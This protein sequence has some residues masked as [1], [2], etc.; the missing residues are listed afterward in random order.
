MTQQ[1]IVTARVEPD[2]IAI[3]DRF[4]LEVTV[5]KDVMQMVDFP[6]FEQGDL[7]VVEDRAVDTL[8]SEG[9]QMTLRKSWT[10]TTFEDGRLSL[11]RVPVL[12]IDKNITDTLLSRDSLVLEVGTFKID[13]ATMTIRDLKP[14]EKAPVK[15]GE[16]SGW[17]GLGLL[18]AA[19]VGMLLWWL[20]RKKRVAEEAVSNELPHERATREL[21]EL[22][23]RKLWQNGK[24]KQYYT[25]L[26]DIL[27]NYLEARWGVA[28][29][30]MTSDEILAAVPETVVL[31]EMLRLADLVKFARMT[32]E[33]EE[34]ERAWAQVYYFVENTKT[35]VNA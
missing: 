3:G 13:T 21:E 23:A 5:E 7:E 31:S 27:R 30:E 10:M 34:N 9:R 29:M 35:M 32:P 16:F 20:R 15:F 19:A 33:A 12:Y 2:S 24:H 8:K 4:T 26:T 6:V 14:L 25:R 18:V 17:L 1:P 11:G 22:N 28:A